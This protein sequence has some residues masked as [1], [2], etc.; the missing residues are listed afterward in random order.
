LKKDYGNE[1]EF[2]FQEDRLT[3]DV[4]MGTPPVAS[5]LVAS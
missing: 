1:K 5:A 3:I 4:D 2:K